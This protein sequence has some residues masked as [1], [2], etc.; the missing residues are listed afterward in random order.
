MMATKSHYVIFQQLAR[1]K[2]EVRQK[3]EMKNEKEQFLSNEKDNNKEQ[4]KKISLAERTAGRVRQEYQE[5]EAQ[6][7]QFHSELDALKRTVDR[8]AVDLETTRAQ[9]TGLKKEQADKQ[10]K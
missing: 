1:V 3:N 8:T 2:A 5:A 10:Q 4:E 7:D 9:V 6:R